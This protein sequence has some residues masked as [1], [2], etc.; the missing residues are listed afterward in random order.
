MNHE[1]REEREGRRKKEEGRRK[2]EEGRRKIYLPKRR[3]FFST[4]G[5]GF[6]LCRCGF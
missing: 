4:H 3:Y 5:G 6:C 2:K 1:G